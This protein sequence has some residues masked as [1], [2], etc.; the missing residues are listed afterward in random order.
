MRILVAGPPK[1][2]NVWIEHILADVYRL[3]ILDGS[4]A[5]RDYEPF[6][7]SVEAGWFSDDSIF[8]QHFSPRRELFDIVDE[9]ETVL[10][11]PVRD[12]YDVFVS[13]YHYAQSFR[14]QFAATSD[15]SG[16]LVGKPID[17]P[18]VFRF[19]ADGFGAVLDIGVGWI[20]SGRSV[21]VR[22]EDLQAAPLDTVESVTRV[23]RPVTDRVIANAVRRNTAAN[24]RRH[25]LHMAAHIRAATVG[26]WQNHLTAKHIEILRD[27]HAQRI[28]VLGYRVL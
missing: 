16:V 20:N 7:E 8:H 2:G 12:P 1:A 21:L 5:A 24:M 3:K 26:D 28:A 10:V 25:S 4:V 17:H 15:P 27:V 13:L 18:D 14:E 11:T 22:Y 6:R 23:I 19:L 9:V